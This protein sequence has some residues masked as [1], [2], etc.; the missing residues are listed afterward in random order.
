MGGDGAIALVKLAPFFGGT[1]KEHDQVSPGYA[2]SIPD[3]L[4]EELREGEPEFRVKVLDAYVCPGDTVKAKTTRAWL[5][6]IP[7]AMARGL[8]MFND[9]RIWRGFFGVHTGVVG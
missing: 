9:A 7:A 3:S 8:Q 1:N 2:P 5:P 4:N 6:A